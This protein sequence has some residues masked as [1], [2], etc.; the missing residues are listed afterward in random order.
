[1]ALKFT[2]R[3]A[4]AAGLVILGLG[5]CDVPA[6]EGSTGGADTGSSACGAGLVVASS[7]YGSSSVGVLGLDGR[8]ASGALITSG[9]QVAGLSTSLSGDVVFPGTAPA[10]GQIVLIDRYPNAVLTWIDPASGVVRGQLS[11]ATGFG[12]NPQDYL[13]LSPTKAY[14]P[15]HTSNPSPGMVPLDHGGDVLV[16]NPQTRA[17]LSSIVFEEA[18]PFQ[19]RPARMRLVGSS[20]WLTLGRLDQDF[21]KAEDGRLV[22]L[23]PTTDAVRW[24]LDFPGVYN[25]SAL[26]YQ[27]KSALVAVSCSGLVADGA[28]EIDHAAVILLDASHEPPTEKLRVTGA[29]LG[30]PTPPGGASALAFVDEERLL[31]VLAGSLDGGRP[32]R[33]VSLATA[34]GSLQE[35]Y[36]AR[37]AFVLG[38]VACTA[39]CTARCFLTD[40][41][42]G[43]VRN[44]AV[45]EGAITDSGITAIAEARGLPPRNLGVFGGGR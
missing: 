32:D 25:C 45:T 23:D 8:V 1:M 37:A 18:A 26:A 11:V 41:E 13:E 20:V 24:T 3:P 7:D 31:V 30:D 15:R 28:H 12:S 39:A 34:D 2:G 33:L 16:I 14:V 27:E 35:I 29:T 44:F 43:G 10:S 17:I 22:G 36:R 5:A 21:Q 38:D 6:P 19:P 4:W 9:A 42:A 40:A